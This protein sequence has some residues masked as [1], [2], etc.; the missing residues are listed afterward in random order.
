MCYTHN[1]LARDV[2]CFSDMLICTAG[3]IL[4][5]HAGKQV[6]R[7]VAEKNRSGVVQPAL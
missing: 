4:R 3:P 6:E 2:V 1:K 5:I 7:T